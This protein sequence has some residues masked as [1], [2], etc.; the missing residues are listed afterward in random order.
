MSSTA[1]TMFCPSK[2][3]NNTIKCSAIVQEN[4]GKT[5]QVVRPCDED[6]RVAHNEKNAGWGYTKEK[7]TAA[8]PKGERCL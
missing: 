1:F 2:T 8:K 5:I 7:K 6:E 3:D 4:D